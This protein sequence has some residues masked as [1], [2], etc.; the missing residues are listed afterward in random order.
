[1]KNKRMKNLLLIGAYWLL[2]LLFLGGGILYAR[3]ERGGIK[4]TLPNALRSQVTEDEVPPVIVPTISREK[5]LERITR[6]EQ[7]IKEAT[8][9]PD[10]A[11]ELR[12]ELQNMREQLAKVGQ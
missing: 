2:G 3:F 12:R 7:E 10:R 1:M 9:D 4:E 8:N 11:L 5:I 6:L